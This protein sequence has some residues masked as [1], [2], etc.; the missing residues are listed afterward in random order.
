MMLLVSTTIFL[1]MAAVIATGLYELI[2]EVDSMDYKEA[3]AQ[4]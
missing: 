1:S 4:T 3:Y 2:W